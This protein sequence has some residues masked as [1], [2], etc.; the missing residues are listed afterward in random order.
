M[1][2][3]KNRSPSPICV[4]VRSAERMVNPVPVADGGIEP[5]HIE[6]GGHVSIAQAATTVCR[7]RA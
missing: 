2:F 4:V 7:S 6:E 1:I 3:V 5:S